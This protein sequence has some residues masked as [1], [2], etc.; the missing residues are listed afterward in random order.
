MMETVKAYTGRAR[1]S[2]DI[3]PLQMS[4]RY[5]GTGVYGYNLVRHLLTIDREN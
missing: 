3:R 1:F 5:Q 4:S 2:L